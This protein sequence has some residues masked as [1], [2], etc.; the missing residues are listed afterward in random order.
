MRILFAVLAVLAMVQARAGTD[1]VMSCDGAGA[2]SRLSSCAILRWAAPEASALVASCTSTCT[3]NSADSAWR[4]YGALSSGKVLRCTKDIT[5]GT[6]KAGIGP[7]PC[8]D[9]SKAWVSVNFVTRTARWTA[10]SANDDNSPLTDLAG[11]HV[12]VGPNAAGPWRLVASPTTTNITVLVDAT[13]RCAQIVARTRSGVEGIPSV[14]C[15]NQP[16]AVTD[17]RFE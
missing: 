7:D 4:T 2:G 14:T 17:A 16:G 11:Y 15:V 3:W 1:L 10:P 13:E 12:R 6:F 8:P 9:A 5:P